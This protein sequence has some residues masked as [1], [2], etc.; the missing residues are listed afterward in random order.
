MLILIFFTRLYAYHIC[1]LAQRNLPILKYRR[2]SHT[3]ARWRWSAAVH[4]VEVISRCQSTAISRVS[5]WVEC[6]ASWLAATSGG[7]AEA[8][9]RRPRRS[10]RV[11]PGPRRDAAGP[12]RCRIHGVCS[13]VDRQRHGTTSVRASSHRE[14]PRCAG[15]TQWWVTGFL[16][17]LLLTVA[18]AS[19]TRQCE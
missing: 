14:I 9:R 16:L 19:T 18:Y 12:R 17:C 7:S 4:A 2:R 10:R 13:A 8:D 11:L 6:V 5:T 1:R 3:S 15:A